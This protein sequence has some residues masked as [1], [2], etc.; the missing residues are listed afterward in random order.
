MSSFDLKYRPKFFR[1]VLGNKGI[2]S[3]LLKRSQTGTLGDQSMMLAGPKGCGKTSIARLIARAL[4]CPELK[5]GEPCGE[6]PICFAI[7]NEVSDSVQE[8]DAASQG[9]VDRVRE[10]VRDIDYG[11]FDGKSQIYIIDEAQ[12]LTTQA[13]D[14]FLKSV[15]DR[16][17]TVI[18]CTTEPHK[19]KGPLRSRVEEYPVTPPKLDEIIFR[20]SQ[21]AKS[22][23]IQTDPE[24]LKIIA[25]INDC[26]PRT[27]ILALQRMSILGPVTVDSVRQ[28][29]RFNSYEL[30]DKIL[31]NLDSNPALSFATL[32]ELAITEGSVWIRDTIALA[33]VSGMRIDIGVKSNYPVPIHFFQTRMDGWLATVKELGNI[34][35]PTISDIEAVLLM[36]QDHRVYTPTRTTPVFSNPVISVP[37]V[38]IIPPIVPVPPIVFKSEQVSEP[39]LDV[40]RN[41]SLEL[42]G[43]KYTSDEQLTTLDNK[44]NAPRDNIPI[45]E[46]DM[47]PVEL[48]KAHVPITEKE[49]IHKFISRVK[50]KG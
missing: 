27:S 22:E 12:R 43:V 44:V 28:F 10:M 50:T 17:F 45:S 48:D 34:E 8:L 42:D 29:F 33:I 30:I 9:S 36:D 23:Q 19:M 5:D 31:F 49:F 38:A 41:R 16:L 32:D 3:L 21:I 37:P 1:D 6:C 7:L 46:K 18:L 26:C 39:V 14:A 25:N 15:E 11:T 24:A 4:R 2:I 13:Q 20:L 47:P 40:I 35:R